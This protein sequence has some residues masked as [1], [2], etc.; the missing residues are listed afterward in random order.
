M[1]INIKNREA[2]ALLAE[3]KRA[4]GKGTSRIVLELLRRE[5]ARL[6]RQR[7]VGARRRRIEAISRRYSAR[8]PARPDSPEALVGY[9]R[10]GL[11]E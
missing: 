2:E 10:S 1:S 9:D 3:V 5:A 11:P 8:L 6:R 4:T 7:E